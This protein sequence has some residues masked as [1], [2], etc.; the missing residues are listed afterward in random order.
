MA[1]KGLSMD[2]AMEAKLDAEK[3][4]FGPVPSRRLG[5]SLGIDP[6]PT[7][8][9]NFNCV[10]CQLGRTEHLTKERGEFF[11]AEEIVEQVEA[12]LASRPKSTVD[13]VTFI[14][15]GETCL[16]SRLGWMIDEVRKLTSLP[17]AVV[18]NGSLLYRP[19]VRHALAAADAVLPRLDAGT[20][21]LYRRINRPH[22]GFTFEHHVDGLI[23]FRR[24]Y[25]GR[26][27]LEIMLVGGENDSEQA[28]QD[29]AAVVGKIE[30]DEIHISLPT[31][32][33]AETW[34]RP[35]QRHVV[36]KALNILGNKARV[37][38]PTEGDFELE[39]GENVVEA[40][41][42]II[43]RHPMSQNELENCLARWSPEGVQEALA[44]LE[45]D[46]R[47]TVVAHLGSRFWT[48]SRTDFPK[49]KSGQTD[50]PKNPCR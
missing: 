7:K 4:V 27:W 3:F 15:S 10:F 24:S 14:A 35:P 2:F 25:T 36:L 44:K 8:T 38:P 32:P 16:H 26:L 42:G 11:Q 23:K 46:G 12:A 31:R 34:V 37:I 47:I 40:V 19:E 39:A 43:A 18:T 50:N 49:E 6:V 1:R 33:P 13:W 9:C 28:L 20:S 48:T 30:P 29:I 45:A 5:Q 22:P 21:A 17:L 41:L